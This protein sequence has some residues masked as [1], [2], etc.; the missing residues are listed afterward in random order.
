MLA[1]VE[2]ARMIGISGFLYGSKPLAVAIFSG[3][4]MKNI[5]I[6]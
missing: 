4:S 5:W 2:M 6:F 3:P 1:E